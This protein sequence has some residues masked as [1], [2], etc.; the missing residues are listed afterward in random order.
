MPKRKA[1]TRGAKG[2]PARATT[3]TKR[4]N[5]VGKSKAKRKKADIKE[6]VEEA[7]EAEKVDSA[8]EV[9]D[10]KTSFQYLAAR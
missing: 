10:D 4:R 2:T 9:D 7:E 1:S 5:S 6:V 8:D 3:T